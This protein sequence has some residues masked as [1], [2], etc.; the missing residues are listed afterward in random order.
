M[1]KTLSPVVA[2]G[3]IA[4]TVVSCERSKQTQVDTDLTIVKRDTAVRGIIDRVETVKLNRPT[5]SSGEVNSGL[6]KYAKLKDDYITAL[7]NGDA[8][9]VEALKVRYNHWAQLAVGWGSKLK[10]DEFQK[11]SEYITKLSEEWEAVAQKALH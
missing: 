6:A 4:A 3:L 5:F 1:K 11:Y 2:I 10:P 8:V 9:Q 7:K